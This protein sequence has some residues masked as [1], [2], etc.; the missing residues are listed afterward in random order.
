MGIF[1]PPDNIWAL[2]FFHA[3]AGAI[4]SLGLGLVRDKRYDYIGQI[5]SDI[6]AV[7]C[8]TPFMKRLCVDFTKGNASSIG[9]TLSL[10]RDELEVL[11]L[12]NLEV[13]TPCSAVQPRIFGQ[14]STSKPECSQT[15]ELLHPYSPLVTAGRD[16]CLWRSWKVYRGCGTSEPSTWS[17]N[18]VCL[19]RTKA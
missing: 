8:F 1:W 12:R 4:E 10:V 18:T 9:R 13:M 14:S 11:C 19:A 2:Q 6:M 3:R 5:V 15:T 7:L 17:F 16:T